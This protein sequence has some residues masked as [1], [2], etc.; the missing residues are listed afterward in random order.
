MAPET[1]TST[2]LIDITGMSDRRLNYLCSFG[3]FGDRNQNPGSGGRRSFTREDLFI[4]AVLVQLA[5]VGGLLADQPNGFLSRF[6]AL[7]V[8]N[9]LRRDS[10]RRWLIVG[11]TTVAVADEI[12]VTGPSV[13]LDLA[14]VVVGDLVAA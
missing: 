13:I 4:A 11:T 14:S 12:A 3:V 10:E 8:A 9:A 2:D 5:A 1:L 6:V 7:G